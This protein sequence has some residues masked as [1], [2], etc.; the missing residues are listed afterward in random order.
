MKELVYRRVAA[1]FDLRWFIALAGM[2]MSVVMHE[3]FH[4]IIHWGDIRGVHVFPDTEAIASVMIVPS[5]DY[6]LIFEE[7]LAYL[8]TMVTL[9]LTA[10]LVA[11]LHDSRDTRSVREMIFGKSSGGR[12]SRSSD[13]DDM[14]HIAGL[15]G[16]DSAK[17]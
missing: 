3:L 17:Y 5:G 13:E 6:D 8:I 7:A 2:V 12:M 11:D 1:I 4:I 15:L 10:K 14:A 16:V 9:L